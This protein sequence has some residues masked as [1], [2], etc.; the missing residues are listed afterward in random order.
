MSVVLDAS[1]MMAFVFDDEQTP[2]LTERARQVLTNGAVVPRH[3]QLEMANSVLMS[4]RRQ[5]IDAAKA[6]TILAQMARLEVS[7]DL[8]DAMAAWTVIYAL[9]EQHS[10]TLYDAAYLELAMR[11]GLPLASLDRALIAAARASGVEVLTG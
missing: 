11:R 3:W 7:I 4:V 6:A 8:P 1:F 9:A 2:E 5:R 10:L